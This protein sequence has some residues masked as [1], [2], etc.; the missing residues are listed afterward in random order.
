[1]VGISSGTFHSRVSL[2]VF[3]YRLA[4]RHTLP[5]YLLMGI[6]SAKVCGSLKIVLRAVNRLP[7]RSGTGVT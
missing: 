3:Y 7:A 5:L 2:P 1:M 6:S 4:D